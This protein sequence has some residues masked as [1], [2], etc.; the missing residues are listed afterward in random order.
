[1]SS[2]ITL[3]SRWSVPL[4]V[5]FISLYASV[6]GV[7][8]YEEFVEG[9]R[10]GFDTAIRILPNLLAMLVVISLAREAGLF[11]LVGQALRPLL[12]VIGLPA[13]V[14]PLALMRPFSGSGALAMTA[15][16]L[17]THGPDTFI[18]RVASTMQ[19]STD[20]T[21]YIITVYFGAVGIRKTR[22]AIAAGL[23]GDAAGVIAAVLVCRFYFM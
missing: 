7:A 12:R 17:N 9:A 10:E 11:D 21:F 4:I 8:V 3:L 13:D 20:T 6:K 15:E 1:M 2:A 18:G 22:H 5:V 14:L 23:A 19:G 16:I